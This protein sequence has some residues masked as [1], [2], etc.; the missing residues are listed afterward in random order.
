MAV[1][2]CDLRIGTWKDGKATVKI[3]INKCF[4]VPKI[5]SSAIRIKDEEDLLT[6][7]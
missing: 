1:R 6:T 7:T 3:I 2:N 5:S 4:R